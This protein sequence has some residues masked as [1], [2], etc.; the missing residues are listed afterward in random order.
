MILALPLTEKKKD[1][2]TLPSPWA[3][4]MAVLGMLALGVLIGSVTDQ[5]S[6]NAGFPTVLLESSAPPPEEAAA[7][8]AT[9]GEPE[10]EAT[11]GEAATV[12]A[13]PSTAPAEAPQV[14]E[15]LPGAPKPEVPLVEEELPTG[16]PEVKHVFVVMLKEGDVE[17]TLGKALSK[18][19]ELLTNYFA[20]TRGALANQI[21]LLSGQGPTPETA[22]NCPNYG[23]LA[24]GT[25]SSEGQVEGNGCAYPATTKTLPGQLTEA[26]LK[27][28][29]YVQGIE[30]GAAAGQPMTCRH[31]TPGTPDPN[32]AAIPG[33]AYETWRNPFVYFHSILDTPECAEANVGLPQLATDLKLEA[34]KFPALAYIAPDETQLETLV[35]EI[36][37]SL[38][39]KD[40]GMIAITSTQAPQEGEGADESGCCVDLDYPNLPD[41]GSET[42]AIGPVRET[43]GGG[44]VGLL[45]LSPYVEPGTTSETYF[46]HFSLLVTIEELFELERIGY[47]AEP[48]LTGFD[49]S[50]FNAAG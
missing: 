16:L 34:E 2:R 15:P 31:P 9:G 27:W 14:E 28:K 21:A 33:D 6:Q 42:P 30:D 3:S 17:G 44:R 49:E 23:D 38:A 20:V 26:G 8:E 32:Q 47:A 35:A 36:R 11:G 5:Y 48:A 22:A 1:E 29:A 24:P 45:L 13:T 4:A 43:G 10:T 12:T 7:P 19:G 25:E 41:A 50:V 46:N 18:Q 39:Y 37:E 40:G